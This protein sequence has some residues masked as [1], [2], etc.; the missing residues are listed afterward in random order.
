MVANM[1]ALGAVAQLSKLVTTKNIEQ[2]L[3]ARIPPGTKE[4]NMRALRLGIKAVKNYD[5]KS[6]PRTI[7]QEEEEL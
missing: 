5:L 2:A 1:V 6:L 4:M 7:I 3:S